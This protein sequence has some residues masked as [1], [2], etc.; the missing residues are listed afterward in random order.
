MFIRSCQS[1]SLFNSFF[2]KDF[3]LFIFREKERER[4]KEG[5]KLWC[6]REALISCLSYT[7][8]PDAGTELASQA[9]A[10]TRCQ[11]DDLLPCRMIDA[12]SVEPHQ[13]GS[14]QWF[15]MIPFY[16]DCEEME[17]PWILHLMMKLKL[18]YL[19]SALVCKLWILALYWKFPKS[20]K[21]WND[22]LNYPFI[23]SRQ[24]LTCV[25]LAWFCPS[26]MSSLIGNWG[27]CGKGRM[28]IH[29]FWVCGTCSFVQDQASWLFVL[30]IQ[31]PSILLNC[32]R[33]LLFFLL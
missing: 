4:E 6:G 11:T 28:L 30:E 2:K 9:G 33:E 5:A 29:F 1:L 13:A 19:Y 32:N 8:W 31:F 15:F 17:I 23:F 12:Q 21:I 22:F 20:L 18:I 3:H 26:H 16:F 14:V 24:G 25:L 10:L 7:H 27:L